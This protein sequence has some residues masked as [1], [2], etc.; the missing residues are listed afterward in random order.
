MPLRVLLSAV[1]FTFSLVFATQG[2]VQ[3]F[4]DARRAVVSLRRC[5]IPAVTPIQC[6]D[7]CPITSR[8]EIPA[9]ST[10]SLFFRGLLMMRGLNAMQSISHTSLVSLS[11]LVRHLRRVLKE[12]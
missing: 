5:Y 8:V 11:S 12:S 9:C 7:L 3:T 10:V 1:G 2:C 6:T 4:S